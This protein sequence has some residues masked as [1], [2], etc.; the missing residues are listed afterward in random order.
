MCSHGEGWKSEGNQQ[1]AFTANAMTGGE[2]ALQISVCA[3]NY[4]QMLIPR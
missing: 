3:H 1:L 2:Q 4:T